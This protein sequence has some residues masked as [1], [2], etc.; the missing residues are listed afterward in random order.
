MTKQTKVEFQQIAS[1]LIGKQV[2]NVCMSAI[3]HNI[4]IE[5]TDGAIL[6]CYSHCGIIKYGAVEGD[7][8]IAE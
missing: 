3:R 1:F 7:S 5:F 2:K 8:N 4:I 6:D